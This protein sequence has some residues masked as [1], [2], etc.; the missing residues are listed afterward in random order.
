MLVHGMQHLRR[1]WRKH[2]IGTQIGPRTAELQRE[3]K[4]ATDRV[5]N[6]VAFHLERVGG[7]PFDDDPTFGP[8][9]KSKLVGFQQLEALRARQ[10][11]AV[12]VVV[13]AGNISRF[14]S[15]EGMVRGIEGP[16]VEI[17]AYD[18]TLPMAIA[19][20]SI[21][22]RVVLM[23]HDHRRWERPGAALLIR[24]R[25]ATE[26]ADNYFSGLIADAPFRLRSPAGVDEDG[27]ARFQQALA[28]QS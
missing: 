19:P 28:D 8:E 12:R 16:N 5:L 22:R 20:L 2:G 23:V 24:S 26:W 27:L 13:S 14:Q 9:L 15:I 6:H 7:A 21:A 3:P 4:S 18:N 1:G 25:A 10:G 17:H 11:W